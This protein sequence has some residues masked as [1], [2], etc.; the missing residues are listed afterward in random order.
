MLLTGQELQT[1]RHVSTGQR[2]MCE[3]LMLV[4]DGKR[5]G[6]KWAYGSARNTQDSGLS[7]SAWT[8]AMRQAGTILDYAT[9]LA[10]H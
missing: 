2:A 3:A 10:P 1:S 9:E 7:S 4:A 5:K 6:G 8:E